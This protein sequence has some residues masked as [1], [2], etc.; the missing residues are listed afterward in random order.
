MTHAPG[1]AKV[2]RFGVHPFGRYP[3]VAP[4]FPFM[5]RPFDDM[6]DDAFY[7]PRAT[8]TAAITSITPRVAFT[9]ARSAARFRIA[10]DAEDPGAARPAR[11]P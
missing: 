1:I 5:T 7:P 3:T 11:G 10:I 9:R 2:T 8:R 6:S 4:T